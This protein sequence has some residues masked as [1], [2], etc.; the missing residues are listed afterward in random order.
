MGHWEA[1]AR[2]SLHMPVSKTIHP[3]IIHYPDGLHD[4]VADRAADKFESAFARLPGRNE[5]DSPARLP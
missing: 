4:G 1:T 5:F 2:S 3:V